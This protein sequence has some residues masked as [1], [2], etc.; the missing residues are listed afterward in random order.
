MIRR[1]TLGGLKISIE[2]FAWELAHELARPD[3]SP[4]QKKYVQKMLGKRAMETCN[5]VMQGKPV[6]D[7]C[8]L[9][10]ATPRILDF[11]VHPC[12]VGH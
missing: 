9:S 4:T 1:T 10:C 2:H 5:E 8:Q 11:K 12:G 6:S 3:L 7:C